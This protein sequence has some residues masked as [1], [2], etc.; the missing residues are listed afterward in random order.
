MI[1]VTHNEAPT[2]LN[3]HLDDKNDLFL[4]LQNP[5]LFFP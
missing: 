4:C 2:Y 5:F 3:P 1:S